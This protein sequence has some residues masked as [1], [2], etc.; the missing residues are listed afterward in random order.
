MQHTPDALTAGLFV[1]GTAGRN[2]FG[3]IVPEPGGGD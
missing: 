2:A 1:N 3:S